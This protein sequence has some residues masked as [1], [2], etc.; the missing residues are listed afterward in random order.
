MSVYQGRKLVCPACGSVM[1]RDVCVSLNGNR[2]PAV[3]DEIRAGRFQRFPC[4]GCGQVVVADGPLI[5]TDF[6]RKHWV[7]CFP[8]TVEAAW[9]VLEH[10]PAESFRRAMI[11]HAAPVI[12]AEADGYLVRTVFGLPALAEK[13]LIWD[14]GLDDMVVEVVKLEVLR[15]PDGP[16]F[17]LAHRPRFLTVEGG[18]L[19]LALD[20]D[21]RVRV[22]RGWYDAVAGGLLRYAATLD[23]V[24]AGPYVDIG[25]ATLPGDQDPD[26]QDVKAT[27]TFANLGP[28]LTDSLREG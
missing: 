19:L 3:V 21:E 24:A 17:D 28:D 10:Q 6:D 27:D 26:W 11:D 22:P 7:G 14:H 9:R 8:R 2:V 20:G 18:A 15:A 12:R 13:I 25:R 5:Y 4:D 16:S 23:A 1:H